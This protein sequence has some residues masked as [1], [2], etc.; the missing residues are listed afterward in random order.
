MAQIFISGG[1]KNGKSTFAESIAKH[2]ST[3]PLYYI[4]TMIPVDEEDENRIITHQLQRE[5]YGFITIEQPRNIEGILETCEHSGFFLLDSLTALLAN[6][7]FTPN[8]DFDDMACNRIATGLVHILDNVQNIV[9]VSDFIYSDACK[10]DVIT[11]EYR[12]SLAR[13]D[14]LIAARCDVVIEAAYTQSI[15]HKG[16]EIFDEIY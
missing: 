15:V 2:S 10:Y 4:A 13:L 3:R 14:R 5:G 11:E 16:R 12:K 9:I 6:E 7:M 8:G 1:C